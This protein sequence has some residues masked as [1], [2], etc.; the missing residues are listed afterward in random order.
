MRCIDRKRLARKVARWID[1]DSPSGGEALI[2]HL[3]LRGDLDAITE[4][5]R[6]SVDPR[7]SAISLSAAGMAHRA[8]KRGHPPAAYNLAMQ[9]FNDADLQGYRH[10][11]RRAAKAGDSDAAR[12]LGRF[13]VRLPHGA[14]RDIRRV[15]P[16]RP[17]D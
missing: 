12:Q 1:S 11:L 14:A 5:A 7:P 17:Y 2:R 3:A 16:R 9:R 15:R 4:L 10:W 6:L 13:E 8:A